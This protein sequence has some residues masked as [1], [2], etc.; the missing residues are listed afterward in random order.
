M[1]LPGHH[2]WPMPSDC[3]AALSSSLE[4]IEGMK[5]TARWVRNLCARE[6]GCLTPG[7]ESRPRIKPV[8]VLYLIFMMLQ[9]MAAKSKADI[10]H[11]FFAAASKSI[12]AAV[13]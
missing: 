12:K 8:L 9:T 5:S 3:T 4:M 13:S 2:C 1:C 11:C 7:L 10:V 6:R